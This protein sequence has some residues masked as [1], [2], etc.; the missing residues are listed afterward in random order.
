M[1]VGDE[2]VKHQQNEK[3]S[4]PEPVL[5]KQE[6]KA[7]ANQQQQREKTNKSK[8]DK[9]NGKGEKQIITEYFVMGEQPQAGKQ[10]QPKDFDLDQIMSEQ[11][12]EQ[13]E[14]QRQ[15]KAA[16]KREMNRFCLLY[17]SPSPRDQA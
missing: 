6:N 10:Q 11:T 4:N 2:P 9:S 3:S 5:R 16:K 15:E 8:E 12:L 13:A 7:K 1:N 14:L 17:T